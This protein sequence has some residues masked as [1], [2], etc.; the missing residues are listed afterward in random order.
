MFHLPIEQPATECRESSTRGCNRSRSFAVTRLLIDSP[1]DGE[2]GFAGGKAGNHQA[3]GIRRYV[4][5]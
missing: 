1:S 4:C 3:I 5:I 2:A